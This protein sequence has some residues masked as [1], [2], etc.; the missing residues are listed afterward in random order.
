MQ[1]LL[2]YMDSSDEEELVR[3]PILTKDE[4][5]QVRDY[6]LSRSY[7]LAALCFMAIACIANLFD[8]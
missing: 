5:N 2:D 4:L 3:P 1:E 6:K 7:P 8:Y